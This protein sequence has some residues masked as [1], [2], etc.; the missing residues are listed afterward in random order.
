M[1]QEWGREEG[2]GVSGRR[3]GYLVSYPD[4][5]RRIECISSKEKEKKAFLPLLTVEDL[6]VSTKHTACENIWLHGNATLCSCLP[7]PTRPAF[8]QSMNR[9]QH[10]LALHQFQLT[11]LI[12]T[13]PSKFVLAENRGRNRPKIDHECQ[14]SE[15]SS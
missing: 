5:K 1:A 10:C 12:G 14:K 11:S 4:N 3:S 7:H 9:I 8:C 2:G 15:H 13:E 6:V